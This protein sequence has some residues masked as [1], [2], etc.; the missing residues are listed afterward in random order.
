MKNESNFTSLINNAK[1]MMEIESVILTEVSNKYMNLFAETERK[2]NREKESQKEWMDAVL[3][4]YATEAKR[5]RLQ[6]FSIINERF[7]NTE[8]YLNLKDRLTYRVN[9]KE[10]SL[11]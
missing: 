5:E 11:V 3:N 10:N 4:K 2:F 6:L 9:R 1:N 7:Y 8:M